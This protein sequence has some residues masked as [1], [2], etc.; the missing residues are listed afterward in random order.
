LNPDGLML[1][2]AG[3]DFTYKD[4][5]SLT[6]RIARAL[7]ARGFRPETPFAVF[8]PNTGPAMIAML[9]GLRAAGAWCN[10]NLRNGV[11]ANIDVLGRGLCKT[12]FFHSSTADMVREILVRVK[13]IEL[14]VCLDAPSEFG[15]SL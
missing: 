3:G 8:G 1:A 10:V 9:G 12:L 11:E 5:R 2:G 14:A 6:I 7:I 13:T 15:P 4:G